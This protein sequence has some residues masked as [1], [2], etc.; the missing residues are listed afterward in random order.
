MSR[1]QDK[2][3]ANRSMSAMGMLQQ[4]TSVILVANRLDCLH[5]DDVV[6]LKKHH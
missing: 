3:N 1:E 4:R 2:A 6:L 5:G